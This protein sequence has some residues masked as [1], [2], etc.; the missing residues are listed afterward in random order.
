VDR[1]VSAA[2]N[3]GVGLLVT[4]LAHLH[5]RNFAQRFDG[6]DSTTFFRLFFL[7]KPSYSRGEGFTARAVSH[8]IP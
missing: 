1:P 4:A 2:E 5:V 3:L 7:I 8:Q 6:L